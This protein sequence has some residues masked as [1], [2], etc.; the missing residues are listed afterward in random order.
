MRE[1]V[2]DFLPVYPTAERA[3]AALAL[4]AGFRKSS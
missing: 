2:G 3:A 1:A 4:L